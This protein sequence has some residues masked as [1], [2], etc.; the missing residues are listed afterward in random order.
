[1]GRANNWQDDALLIELGVS[2]ELFEAGFRWLTTYFSRN[3]QAEFRADT[4]EARPVNT[5]P[6]TIVPLPQEEID[7]RKLG[8]VLLSAPEYGLDG[9]A[10]IVKLDVRVSTRETPVGPPGVPENQPIY[11]VSIKTKGQVLELYID[12]AR[13]EIHE[14]E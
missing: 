5:D 8:Q 10:L 12:G 13:W 14:F 6:Q 11:H 3:A 9:E 1:M 2:C 7:F 4:A